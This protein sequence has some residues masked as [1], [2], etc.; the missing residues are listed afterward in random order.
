MIEIEST[1]TEL[2]TLS[3]ITTAI[4]E[5]LK[6][7]ATSFVRTGYLLKRARDT[8]T[9]YDGG[10]TS[11]NDYAAKEFGLSKDVVSRYIAINDRYS[12]DGYSDHLAGNYEGYGYAKLAEMLTLP[13]HIVDVISP[14]MTKTDIQELKKEYKEEM[15]TSD[16][17]AA[18]VQSMTPPSEQSVV[19]QMILEYFRQRPEEYKELRPDVSMD[20]VKDILCPDGSRVLTGRTTKGTM[21]MRMESDGE[22]VP[23]N[24]RTGEEEPAT[25]EEVLNVMQ[26]IAKE[27]AETIQAAWMRVFGEGYPVKLS[28][29][30]EDKPKP[31]KKK[32]V[33]PI[34]KVAPVQQKKTEPKK[35]SKVI[36]TEIPKE[37]KT[38]KMGHEETEKTSGE[39]KEMSQDE[40]NRENEAPVNS[41]HDIDASI[42]AP[43]PIEKPQEPEAEEN[44]SNEE[45]E[46][47]LPGQADISDYPE[48]MPEHSTENDT[49]NTEMV[50]EP[51]FEADMAAVAGDK[52][53]ESNMR[54]DA[55][56][57]AQMVEDCIDGWQ[58]EGE[59][60]IPEINKCIENA[61]KCIEK[62]EEL[63]AS[64][65]RRKG[66]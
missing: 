46:E 9:L 31:E 58:D 53:S 62:L 61:Q 23:K 59:M 50:P 8:S 54:E 15:K 43:S 64:M 26:I 56:E 1:S 2:A 17:E 63:K 6:G 14:D 7:Q 39:K 33:E 32:K 52:E 36:R 41:L 37:K 25:W 20:E 18:I 27:E 34:R 3:D 4:K 5:E 24:M 47:Q 13:D 49:E 42:P 29:P 21:I 12:E 40:E 51:D 35:Q 44:G 30:I 16:I 66:E 48:Y 10:Y 65:E 60:P 57:L 28:Q 38:E 22:V 19:E 11:V 55:L 45:V